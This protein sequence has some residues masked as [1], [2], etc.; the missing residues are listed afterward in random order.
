MAGVYIL[1]AL[2]ETLIPLLFSVLV[3]ML[4]FPV[5]SRLERWKFPRILAIILSILLFI[6]VIAALIYLVTIQVAS[7]ADELPRLTEKAEALLEQLTSMG[8][9]YLNV[10]RS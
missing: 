5:C 8:E 1:H 3:S 4:L 7:F 9:R 2:H 6:V 10:S